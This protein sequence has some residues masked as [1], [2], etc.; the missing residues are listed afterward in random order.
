MATL[1]EMIGGSGTPGTFLGLDRAE[2][3]GAAADIVIYGADCA[4]PYPWVGAYC[5][6]GPTAIRAGSA[7]YAG[8]VE[9]VNFDLMGPLLPKGVR[10]VDAGDL[11]TEPGDPSGNRDRIEAATRQILGNGA[12]PVLLG[13]DD[14]VPL[15]MLR[16]FDGGAPLT[17]LQIDAHID[18]RDE[19]RGNGW[20]CLRRCV[21]QAR[22]PM[23]SGSCRSARGVSARRAWRRW[24]RRR[25]GARI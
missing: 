16:A 14:S 15:G 13:G 25:P 9:R 3:V 17:I 10:A 21:G 11:A 8:A 20:G 18:W 5:A 22:W 2:S 23:S 12:V 4:T 6:G 7:D 24:R 1:A 19:V